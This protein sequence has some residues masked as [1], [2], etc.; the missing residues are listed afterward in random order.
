MVTTLDLREALELIA[1][2]E[3]LLLHGL[4]DGTTYPLDDCAEQ[5]VVLLAQ[6]EDRLKRAS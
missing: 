6:A 3:R 5:A 2:A 4:V 1:A